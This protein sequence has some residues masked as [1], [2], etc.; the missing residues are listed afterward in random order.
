MTVAL[1]VFLGYHLNM[2]RLNVTTNET[3]KKDDC[4][5]AVRREMYIIN[6]IIEETEKW[7]PKKDAKDKD[8]M[9]R[10]RID[11]VVQP[12]SRPARLAKLKDRIRHCEDKLE[13]LGDASPYKPAGLINGIISVF[14]Y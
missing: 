10:L 7:T 12:T 6:E 5:Y 9:P 3:L 8:E 4:R 11:G 14:S 13:V 2:I 1:A